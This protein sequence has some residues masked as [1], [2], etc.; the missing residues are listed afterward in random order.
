MLRGDLVCRAMLKMSVGATCGKHTHILPTLEKCYTLPH[1]TAKRTAHTRKKNTRIGEVDMIAATENVLKVVLAGD[2]TISPDETTAVF[3]ILSGNVKAGCVLN[4]VVPTDQPDMVLSREQVANLLG[5]S[6]GAVDIY[7]RKGI[8]RRV[9]LTK[10]GTMRQQAQGYSRA[11][12][13]AAI[14]NGAGL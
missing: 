14:K 3:K 9:Y 7:G 8:I 4:S 6:K 12:V 1:A 11:S 10:G 13:M 5:K 2:S